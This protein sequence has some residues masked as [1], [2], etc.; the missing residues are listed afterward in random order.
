MSA[1]SAGW[2][3]EWAQ[4]CFGPS[5]CWSAP[6][7]VTACCPLSCLPARVHL[8]RSKGLVGQG[9][10]TH[11]CQGRPVL[12]RHAIAGVVDGRD[13]LGEADVSCALHHAAERSC[14]GGDRGASSQQVGGAQ[15]QGVHDA[16]GCSATRV[17]VRRHELTPQP[18]FPPF[19]NLD[20]RNTD[21]WGSSRP[22]QQC[23]EGG[24]WWACSPAVLVPAPWWSHRQRC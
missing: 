15:K 10:S 13:V 19:L 12:R 21:Q 8:G 1:W 6:D 18:P 4:C 3:S 24:W 17:G 22:A 5:A 7:G 20:N 16:T 9:R 14:I 2:R 23:T 11:L